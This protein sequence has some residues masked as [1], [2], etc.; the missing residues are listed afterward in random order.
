M[1]GISF[2]FRIFNQNMN[3]EYQFLKW[4]EDE[5]QGFTERYSDETDMH[6]PRCWETEPC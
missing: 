6:V 4:V 1:C 2:A 3:K 5:A